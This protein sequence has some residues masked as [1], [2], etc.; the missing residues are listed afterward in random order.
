[1][2]KKFKENCCISAHIHVSLPR[3]THYSWLVVYIQPNACF[4]AVMKGKKT[5]V[6]SLAHAFDAD[7]VDKRRN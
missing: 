3:Q 1:M 6:L 5:L 4:H 2:M 7:M